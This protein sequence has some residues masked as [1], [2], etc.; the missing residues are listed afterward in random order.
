MTNRLGDIPKKL[1]DTFFK[2]AKINLILVV[3]GFSSRTVDPRDLGMVSIDQKI[4]FAAN[5][6]LIYL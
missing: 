5:Y 1:K 3:F 2:M 6:V 4:N